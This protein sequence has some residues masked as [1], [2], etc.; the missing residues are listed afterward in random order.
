MRCGSRGACTHETLGHFNTG[1][2]DRANLLS[3][4]MD[5]FGKT[6]AW[7]GIWIAEGEFRNELSFPLPNP[8]NR[9]TRIDYS[10]KGA[11]RL[12]IEA[13]DVA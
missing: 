1:I 12:T 7:P 4:I 13:Y 2:E 3:N 10:M 5:Y 8:F 11:G 9:M 6:T